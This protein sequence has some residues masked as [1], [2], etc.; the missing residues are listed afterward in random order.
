MVVVKLKAS[1]GTVCRIKL[2]DGVVKS[3]GSAHDRH[4]PIAHAVH[5]IQSAGFI[6]RRHQKHV[7]SG[8]D[9][10][11]QRLTRVAFVDS[12]LMRCAVVPA[13]QKIFV[14]LRARAE[15]DEE[16]ACFQNGSGKLDESDR[17]PSAKP[18]G[19]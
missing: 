16:S 14:L 1:S 17:N 3:A 6:V 11:G 5:L 15:C 2:L 12:H 9:L 19:K 4:R 10:M 8:F 18:A 7:G 13:L